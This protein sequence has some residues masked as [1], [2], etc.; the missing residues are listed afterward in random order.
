M[1]LADIKVG[2]RVRVASIAPSSQAAEA[3]RLGIVPGCEL[4]VLTKVQYGPVVV[5]SG[6]SEVAIGYRL[7]RRIM[8]ERLK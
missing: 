6:V 5:Q 2:Q 4:V 8:V 1:T 3:I 7:A